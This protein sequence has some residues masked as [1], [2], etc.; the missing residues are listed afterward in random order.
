MTE[1][2]MVIYLLE[3]AEKRNLLVENTN[4]TEH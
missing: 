4:I 1:N 3:N 2:G